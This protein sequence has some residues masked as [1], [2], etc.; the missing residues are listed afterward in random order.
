[1]R[2]KGLNGSE[3]VFA[4]IQAGAD[5]DLQ[6]VSCGGQREAGRF[7]RHYGSRRDRRWWLISSKGEGQAG[8][9]GGA[10]TSDGV[11]DAGPHHGG[12]YRMRSSFWRELRG[13][14]LG[15]GPQKMM[16]GPRARR[17]VLPVGRELGERWSAR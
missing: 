14:F 8:S 16:Q 7:E 10:R 13:S 4:V 6:R 1:M 12:Q 17:A 11:T 5:G 9:K 3:T 15:R 2:P